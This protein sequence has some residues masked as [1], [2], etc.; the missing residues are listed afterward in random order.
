MRF[1]RLR[2]LVET[3]GS[4]ATHDE[5]KF[6][7]FLTGVMEDG[8]VVDGVLASSGRQYDELWDL[9]ELAAAALSHKAHLHSH[10]VSLPVS[11]MPTDV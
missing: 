2:F 1:S 6:D 3:A 8:L 10:D 11:G 9:R 4:N 5:E 7:A